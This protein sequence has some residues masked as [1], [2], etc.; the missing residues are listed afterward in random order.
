MHLMERGSALD[1]A[2]AAGAVES[3]PSGALLMRRPPEVPDA[4]DHALNALAQAMAGSAGCEV[5]RAD[6]G[7]GADGAAVKGKGSRR[8]RLWDLPRHAHCPVIG[9]C[10]SMGLLRRLSQR[11]VPAELLSNDYELHC[12]AVQAAAQRGD[13]SE[14][15]Q[16]GLEE[17]CALELRHGG[18]LRSVDDLRTRWREAVRRHDLSRWLWVVL[19]H[20]LCDAELESEVLHEMHML[21]HQVGTQE[22]ADA[23]RLLQLE[24]R[25][26]ERDRELAAVR[27]RLQQSTARRAADLERLQAQLLQV[28]AQLLGRET[29][30]AQLHDELRRLEQEVPELRSREALARQV[31]EQQE[32][33]QE[34]ERQLRRRE[35]VNGGHRAPSLRVESDPGAGQVGDGELLHPAPEAATALLQDQVVLCVGGRPASVP[36]YRHIVEHQGG[37]FLHH[38]GGEESHVAQLDAQLGAADLVLCQAGCIS[39]NAYWRVKDH[40]KRTGKRCVFLERPST[41]GLLR[42]LERLEPPV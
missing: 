16:R 7:D 42:S 33:L 21:Q 26:A 3:S 32:R 15:L 19:T 40:C 8:R 34:L 10:L 9:G 13:W 38:D 17:R 24:A 35:W 14:S 20:P 29:L 12:A 23:K 5:S 18:S 37:R 36:M 2:D 1:P 25:L 4:R 31:A 30:M 28:R 41:S 11:F 6:G 39:H 22:R 27:A